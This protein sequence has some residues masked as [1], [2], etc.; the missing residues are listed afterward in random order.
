MNPPKNIFLNQPDAKEKKLPNSKPN[1]I[2]NVLCKNYTRHF[3]FAKNEEIF[4]SFF[5]KK[6][7]KKIK[8]WHAFIVQR[9][10][11]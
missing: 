9:N 10:M 1:I 7:C 11:L 4:F 6:Q 2:L 3:F 5:A 8:R